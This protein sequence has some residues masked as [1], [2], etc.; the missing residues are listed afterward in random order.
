MHIKLG[1]NKSGSLRELL[2]QGLQRCV[3]LS[4]EERVGEGLGVRENPSQHQHTLCIT[5]MVVY[6]VCY[7]GLQV[8][9]GDAKSY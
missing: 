9:R 8:G 2:P 1:F 4:R 3:P 6:A 7:I 5:V